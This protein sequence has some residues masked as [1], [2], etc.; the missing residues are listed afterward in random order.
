M[1]D[2][3]DRQVTPPKG[4]TSHTWGPQTPCKQALNVIIK[5]KYT[6]FPRSALK[7]YIEMTPKCS[8]KP[9][10]CDSWS[11]LIFKHFDVIS[12]V[13]RRVYIPWKI[14]IYLKKII[15]DSFSLYIAVNYEFKIGVWCECFFQQINKY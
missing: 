6:N 1:T 7:Q 14:V 3:M 15:H 9:L 13:C 12:V 8:R 10:A 5:I 11:Y 4:V 2:Y